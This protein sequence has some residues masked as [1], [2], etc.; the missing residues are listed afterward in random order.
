MR[1]RANGGAG[2]DIKVTYGGEAAPGRREKNRE[3]RGEKPLHWKIMKKKKWRRGSSREARAGEKPLKRKVM[4]KRKKPYV[5]TYEK[6]IYLWRRGSSR[7]A[8][9]R[10]KPLY[11]KIMKKAKIRIRNVDKY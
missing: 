2:Q 1:G 9:L 5:C 3:L 7:E 4:K 6:K 8:M 11:G 10:E